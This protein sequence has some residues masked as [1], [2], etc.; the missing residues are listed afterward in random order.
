[1]I[2][3]HA[4]TDAD[5]D[6]AGSFLMLKKAFSEDQ[7]TYSVTTEKKFRNS[8][9]S[10]LEN[11]DFSNYDTVF[12]CDLNIKDDISL[13]DRDNVIVFDHH[14]EHTELLDQYTK[15][16]PVVK[17]YSSCTLLMYEAL[18]LKDKLNDY[19]K[20]LVK[21]V[22]DYDS[23]QLKIPYS[24]SLNQI[25]WNYTGDR[26]HKFISDFDNGFNG[27]NLYHK[28]ALRIVERKINDYFKTEQLFK[29]SIKLGDSQ[30]T[31][32][33][34]FFTFPPNEISERALRENNGDIIILMNMKTKTC[35]F[36]KAK[37]CSVNMGKLAEKLAGGG[38][39]EDAAGCL[40]NDNIIN[41]TKLLEPICQK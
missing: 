40:L 31:I 15:A 16:K 33:G 8:I 20:L 19:Q 14:K 26:V 9:L 22:D 1:M 6:G 29:G 35:T 36:R 25:F 37:N 3:I 17:D 21:I 13:I 41:I 4:F 5:L 11:D 18:K 7:I 10:W 30:Y 34:G 39:H 27:F 23:Y 12:I 2:K 32:L 28:N 38:G 24:R